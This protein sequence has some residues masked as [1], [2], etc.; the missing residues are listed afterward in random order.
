M[1]NVVKARFDTRLSKVQKDFFE[2]AASIGGY[3]SLT[4]FV[5]ASVQEKANE[6][7]EQNSKIVLS[8]KAQEVFFNEIINPSKPNK[9]LI[10]AA[11]RYK[12]LPALK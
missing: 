5:V 9:A 6:I 1:E 3:R 4:D 7:V 8:K 12:N 2:Y 11:H 10:A